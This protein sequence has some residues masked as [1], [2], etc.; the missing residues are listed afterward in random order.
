MTVEPL[1]LLPMSKAAST[2]VTKT[3]PSPLLP[4]E[5][6]LSIAATIVSVFESSTIVMIDSIVLYSAVCLPVPLAPVT[7][8]RSPLP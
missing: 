2:G 4:V 8:G 6:A 5:A 3:L 7:S 1:C